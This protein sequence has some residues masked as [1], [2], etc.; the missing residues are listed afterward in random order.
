MG[1]ANAVADFDE[2]YAAAAP[3]VVRQVYALTG[4]LEE[5]RDV[6]QEAFARAWNRWARLS[7]Y[8]APEAWVRTVAHRLA[9]SAWRRGV[10]RAAAYRRH[11]PA[12]DVAAP[13]ADAV[14]LARGLRALPDNH[15][16][17]LVLHYLADLSVEQ[18]AAE[19]GVPSGSVKAWLSRGRAALAA[20]IGSLDAPAG[21]P[22][23]KDRA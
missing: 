5:A 4:D 17:V 11:G 16:R 22:A 21:A 15:R 3:G 6:A 9:V 10:T 2:F 19:M 1:A 8:D 7:S 12:A 13:D 18:I 20:A 14:V 23:G